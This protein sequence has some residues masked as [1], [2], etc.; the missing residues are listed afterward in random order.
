M[1]IILLLLSSAF[2]VEGLDCNRDDVFCIHG[3]CL[4]NECK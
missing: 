3:E 4:N 2:I 1:I